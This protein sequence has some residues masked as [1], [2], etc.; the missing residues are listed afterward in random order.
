MELLSAIV[1]L[2]TIRPEDLAKPKCLIVWACLEGKFPRH[3]QNLLLILGVWWKIRKIPPC[4][5]TSPL[6]HHLYIIHLIN[7]LRYFYRLVD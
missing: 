4:L 2:D 6:S 5:I 1:T 3:A 7:E